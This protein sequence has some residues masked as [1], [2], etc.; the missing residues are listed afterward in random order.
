[1]QSGV[2]KTS[3]WKDFVR[4]STHG[5]VPAEAGKLVDEHFLES[6]ALGLDKPWRGAMEGGDPEK[7]VGLLRNKKKQKM[8]YQRIQVRRCLLDSNVKTDDLQN[9]ILLHPL[10]PLAFRLTV[11]AT[12]V[13][14]LG[15]SGSIYYL[16]SLASFHQNPSTIMAIG[17]D[18]IALPYIG[19][20]TWDEYAGKPLGLRSPKAKMTLVLLDLF[21]IMFESANL[22]LAFAEQSG[23]IGVCAAGENGSNRGICERVKTLCTFLFIALV[24]WSLTFSVSIFRY[25]FLPFYFVSVTNLDKGW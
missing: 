14:A 23:S 13:I 22:A 25:Y 12:S 5:P 19:Y 20:V 16:T 3:Q 15:L 11:L 9:V 1:M 18:I 24:A 21:F 17:V 6:Q 4:S 2:Q 8:W 7:A 10:V